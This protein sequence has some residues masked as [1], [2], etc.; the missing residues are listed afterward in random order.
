LSNGVDGAYCYARRVYVAE[1]G[2][3]TREEKMEGNIFIYCS[4]TV[5]KRT[6]DCHIK[7]YYKRHLEI[8]KSIYI[9]QE[10]TEWRHNRQ[11]SHSVA[12]CNL[13]RFLKLGL[14]IKCRNKGN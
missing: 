12:V 3:R 2:E 9:I 5:K 13:V 8:G 6:A 7:D 14:I 10:H 1:A 4:Q 11:D